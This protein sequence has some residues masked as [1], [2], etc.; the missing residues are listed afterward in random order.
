MSIVTAAATFVQISRDELEGWLDAIGY[1][2]KWERDARSAGLYFIKLSDNVAVKLSSTIGSKDDA[3]GRGKA[4]MQLA[5]ISSVTGSVINKKAQGQDHFKRTTGW[6]KTWAAG[7]ETMKRAYLSS[8]DFYDVIAGIVDRDAYKDELLAK[9]KTVPGWDNDPDLLG[10]YRK[11]ER[12]GVIMPRERAILEDKISN[13]AKPNPRFAPTPRPE[14]RQEPTRQEPVQQD[15]LNMSVKDR[16]N[17]RMDALRKLW[18]ESRRR[19]D[20]W[21]MTFA[22]DIAQ[23]YISQGRTITLPQRRIITEKLKSYR[24]PDLNGNPAHELF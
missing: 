10:Y 9:I 6:V 3:M 24:I 21:T 12:G 19:N 22:Q 20:N 11:I 14:P 8:S 4:S 15:L 5:L 13:P 16:Q 7:I 2:G 23:K 18:L 17:L 1:R